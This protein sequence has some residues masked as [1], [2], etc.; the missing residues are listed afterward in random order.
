MGCEVRVVFFAAAKELVGCR[1]ASL[2]VPSRLSF[3]E[4]KDILLEKYE[5]L[6]IL[7]SNFILAKNQEYLDFEGDALVVFKSG[8]ELAV[9]P[10]ISGG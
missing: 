8:D 5:A 10:P 6:K 9:I 4:L 2:S 7:E 1:E 3:S